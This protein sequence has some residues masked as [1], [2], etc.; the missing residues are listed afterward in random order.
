MKS[1][2]PKVLHRIAGK[3]MLRHVVDTARALKPRAIHVVVGYGEA[4]IRAALPGDDLSWVVQEEQLGTGHA[5]LQALPA[6]NPES[7]VLVL[8]GDVPLIQLESVERLLNSA[9]GGVALLTAEVD[10][11][12][13]LGRILRNDTGAVRGVMEHRD[14]SPEQ[15]AIKE[16]N[17]GVIAA[18]AANLQ[19]W[20][21]QVKADNDQQEYYLPDIFEPALD[22]GCVIATVQP[23]A[24]WEIRG[25]N[26]RVQ[27]A[28]LER[29]YQLNY[30][31]QLMLEGV[32]LADPARLDVRGSLRCG[33]D[34]T[35]DVNVVFCG[36]VSLGDGVTIGANCVISDSS[37][38]VGTEVKANSMLEEA[39]VGQDC[40]VG[41]YARL[42]PG[43][44]L[45]DGAKV[46]NFVETK[47]ARIGEGSKVSHLSYIGDS[48]LGSG[49]NI[50][51]GTI[52]CNYDGVNKYRTS[53]GDG[54]FV[55]SNS[56]LVAPIE[57]GKDG[58]VAAGT[59]LT[60]PVAKGSLAVGRAKQR[61]IKHWRRPGNETK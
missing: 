58:F 1:N 19:R 30:A 61:N 23:G 53:I 35:I 17:T 15:R 33:K 55:G 16:I 11:A 14:A 50:G 44:E 6:V 41:P 36:D 5:V 9:E 54:A 51:A 42:R 7:L 27:L 3:E 28:E 46:G 21:P 24:L 37:V 39:Q 48:D 25:I 31:R 26:D 22:E 56:T 47:N 13:G 40:S 29:Q 38:G 49:V 2:L 8:C 43:S 10:D 57:I 59:T 34:V 52:T 18:G 20:L 4:E 12:T 60:K 45:A 32:T